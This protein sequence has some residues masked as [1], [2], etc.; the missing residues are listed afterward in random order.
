MKILFN[1]SSAMIRLSK[2]ELTHIEHLATWGV[3]ALDNSCVGCSKTE[4]DLAFELR[5]VNEAMNEGQTGE[6]NYESKL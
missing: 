4:K 3:F 6:R 1:E 2:S 5:A